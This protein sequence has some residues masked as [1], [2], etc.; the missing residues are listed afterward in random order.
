MGNVKLSRKAA[1][2]SCNTTGEL[3]L[4]QALT[5]R[6]LAFDQ[7]KLCS[8]D[9]ME[10]WRNFMMQALMKEPPAG[11]KYVTAQQ[12]IAADK[13]LW[14][15]LS[16]R[17]RGKLRV[18]PGGDPPM[19]GDFTELSTSPLVLCVMT[20]L[21]ASKG[22]DTGGD[23][24][25]EP[26]KAQPKTSKAPEKQ[27]PQTNKRKASG[28]GVSVKEL[29]QSMPSDC[30]SKTENGKFICLRY[31]NG[32]CKRQKSSSCNMGVHICYRKGCGKKRPYIECSH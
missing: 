10:M 16:Q 28:S 22:A 1:D 32:T 20:P 3:R 18:D 24:R 8:F 26:V 15:L 7:C 29:L 13:E 25:S 30:T 11:H 19:N 9:V 14:E 5:R 31:N 12:V 2:L 23:S 4:R 21:P 6:S 17:T 27:H